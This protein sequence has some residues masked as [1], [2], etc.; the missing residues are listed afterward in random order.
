MDRMERR[1]GVSGM[2]R[3]CEREFSMDCTLLRQLDGALVVLRA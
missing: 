3:R 2:I 1:L